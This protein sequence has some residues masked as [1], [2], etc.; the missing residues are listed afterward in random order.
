MNEN[1]LA[2]DWEQQEAVWFSWPKSP[3]LWNGNLDL[4]QSQFAKLYKLISRF[5]L[6][7]VLCPKSAEKKLQEL[8]GEAVEKNRVELWEY[9]TDD[10]WCRDFG[11]FFVS[12]K[13]GSKL[14]VA[15]FR[16][17]A[18]G[19][20]FDNFSKDDAASKFIAERLEFPYH[21][22]VMILEGGAIDCNGAHTI[23]T[24]ESVVLNSNR[25]GIL[26]KC[27]FEAVVMSALN[28]DRVLWL[29]GG[30]KD[31]DTDG[32]VD[33]VARFYGKNSILYAE[34]PEKKNPNYRTL[35]ENKRRL[36][37]FVSADGEKFQLTPLPLPNPLQFEEHYLAASYLNFLVLNGA[38]IFPSFGEAEKE[39]DV[40]NTLEKCYPGRVAIGF[41]CRQ[42]IEEGGA[43]HCLSQH[44]PA[45]F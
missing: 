33:N 8:L 18:W 14:L 10:V 34:V 37:S 9:E 44:Q 23:L 40:Q 21:K 16:F 28:I 22:H 35:F 31:D 4:I 19:K 32:H 11:P 27:D 15:D 25:S 24:T 2:A 26:E 17:N 30:L 1:R 38:V 29:C 12:N 41:D 36:Q 7:R 45:T 5:Q 39:K 13:E 42:I 3:E 43:L 6:V 20:K